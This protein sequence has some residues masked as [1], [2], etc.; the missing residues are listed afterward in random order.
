MN[1]LKNIML[2]YQ[3]AYFVYLSLVAFVKSF[4]RL[5]DLI[6][7]DNDYLCYTTLTALIARDSCIWYLD[8]GCSRHMTGNKDYSRL[9]LKERLGQSL[10]EMEA[11]L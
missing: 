2:I 9:S 3:L 11:N 7:C 10:L 4:L 6:T 1:F 8:S 5:L